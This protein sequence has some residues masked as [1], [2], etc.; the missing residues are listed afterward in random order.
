MIEKEPLRQ[1]PFRLSRRQ[2]VSGMA[3]L[4]VLAGVPIAP[5]RAQKRIVIPERF[6]ISSPA[7]HPT[8]TSALG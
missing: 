7:R 5:A 8:A 1:M 6:P 2:L 3:S 4:G